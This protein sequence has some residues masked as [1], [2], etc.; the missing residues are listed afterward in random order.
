[1]TTPDPLREA[2]VYAAY[3]RTG[4]AIELLKRALQAHPERADIRQSLEALER[5][6]Q[7]DAP[8]RRAWTMALAALVVLTLVFAAFHGS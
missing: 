3:G 8:R 2:E 4:Q 7:A 1:M 5:Q 6:V